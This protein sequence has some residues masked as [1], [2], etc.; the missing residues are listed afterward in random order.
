M[1]FLFVINKILIYVWMAL[2][3]DYIFLKRYKYFCK[4][5]FTDFPN[6]GKLD[7]STILVKPVAKGIT[8][9]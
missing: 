3:Y 8:N 4:V 6:L 9:M 1:H 5:I 2:K 7:P